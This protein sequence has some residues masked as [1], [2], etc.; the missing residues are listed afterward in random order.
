ML[1]NLTKSIVKIEK[2]GKIIIVR[3]WINMYIINKTS[4]EKYF[5]V[6]LNEKEQFKIAKR[7]NTLEKVI[8]MIGKENIKEVI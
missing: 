1:K 6:M 3:R 4:N 7:C 5:I 2:Y 8:K